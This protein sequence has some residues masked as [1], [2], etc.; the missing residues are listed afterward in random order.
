MDGE[1]E[2]G[3]Q[4]ER[5]VSNKLLVD[6]ARRRRLFGTGPLKDTEDSV[7]HEARAARRDSPDPMLPSDFRKKIMD[8]IAQEEREKKR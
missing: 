7:E 3:F 4:K 8:R 2:T 6:A 1:S 5:R